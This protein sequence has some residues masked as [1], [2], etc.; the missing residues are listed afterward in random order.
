MSLKRIEMINN[1]IKCIEHNIYDFDGEYKLTTNGCVPE[2][3]GFY[4]TIRCGLGGIYSMIN[5]FKNGKWQAS[6]ADASTTIAFSKNQFDM[7]ELIKSVDK[8]LGL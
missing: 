7:N 4:L 8:E 5:E 1:R 3:D 2:K 6:V